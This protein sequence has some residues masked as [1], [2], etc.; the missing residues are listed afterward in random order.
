[1]G[2]FEYFRNRRTPRNCTHKQS[3]WFPQNNA[4]TNQKQSCMWKRP[5]DMGGQK[6]KIDSSWQKGYRNS[7]NHYLKPRWA[8]KH[9]RMHWTSNQTLMTLLSTRVNQEQESRGY[10]EHRRIWSKLDALRLEIKKKKTTI[11]WSL[12]C[13]TVGLDT[14]ATWL[15][16]WMSR[17]T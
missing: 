3:L 2:R 9:L 6:K 17:W 8:Q 10:H 15:A 16:V 13:E 5:A 4:K 14:I 7:N 1:M 12:F 11:T